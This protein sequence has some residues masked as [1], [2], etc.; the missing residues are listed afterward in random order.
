MRQTNRLK[1]AALLLAALFCL[2]QTS[3]GGGQGAA[4][5]PENAAEAAAGPEEGAA[6]E[7]AEKA[8]SEETAETAENTEKTEAVFVEPPG[9]EPASRSAVAALEGVAC[10]GELQHCM[11]V[12]TQ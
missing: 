12:P 2:T 9:E 1:L 5:A 7:N 10:Q 3:C 11:A 6:A 4:P 8:V